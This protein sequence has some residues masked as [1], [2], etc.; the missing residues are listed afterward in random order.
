MYNF[1]PFICFFQPV[2]DY[3]DIETESEEFTP[4][5]TPVQTPSAGSIAASRP[6][7]HVTTPEQTI[8]SEQSSLSAR[9]E[10]PVIDMNQEDNEIEEGCVHLIIIVKTFR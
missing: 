3:T 9:D 7:S 6:A 1:D 4:V 8:G 2:D 10:V 5:K